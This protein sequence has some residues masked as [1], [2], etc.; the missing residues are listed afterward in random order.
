MSKF[1]TLSLLLCSLWAEAP[2]GHPFYQHRLQEIEQMQRSDLVF[3]GDSLTRRNNWS[4]FNA[5]NMGIDGDTTE[6]VFSRI[7]F[8]KEAKRVVLMIGVNDILKQT[9]LAAIQKNYTKILNSFHKEQEIYIL[10]LLPVVDAAQTKAINKE[11]K[12]LNKWLKTEVREHRF[13]YIELYPHFLDA[14]ARGLK[15]SFTSDGIHLTPQA[16]ALWERL[17]KKELLPR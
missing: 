5:S 2:F 16:Y 6:G 11:I 13:H 4:A 15:E 3:L 7:R 1:L 17:L 9:P 12:N 8:V 14:R 10:S